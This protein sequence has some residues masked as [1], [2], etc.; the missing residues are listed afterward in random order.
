MNIL[1]F[2]KSLHTSF[3]NVS[4]SFPPN[5][6]CHTWWTYLVTFAIIDIFGYSHAH[7]VT[8][9]GDKA[10]SAFDAKAS[11]GFIKKGSDW[12]GTVGS[13]TSSQGEWDATILKSTFQRFTD[14]ADIIGGNPADRQYLINVKDPLTNKFKV[15]TSSIVSSPVMPLYTKYHAIVKQEQG[16]NR[17]FKEVMQPLENLNG[18]GMKN[19]W[20]HW[21]HWTSFQHFDHRRA[22]LWTIRWQKCGL[23]QKQPRECPCCSKNQ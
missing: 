23:T 18:Q 10:D 14:A 6:T 5:T 11:Q 15:M 3:R 20:P 8:G 9:S 12:T 4:D 13:T 7:K 19:I 1:R 21:K 2:E 22:A 16:D 17:E